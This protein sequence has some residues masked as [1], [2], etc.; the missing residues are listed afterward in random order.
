MA[1]ELESRG[2]RVVLSGNKGNLAPIWEKTLVDD[3]AIVYGFDFVADEPVSVYNADV[4]NYSSIARWKS[5]YDAVADGP[6][7]IIINNAAIDVP[8]HRTGINFFSDYVNTI[9]TNLIG[10][11]NLVSLFIDDMKKNRNGLIINIGSIQGNVAA[12]IRNYP[13]GFEKPVGYNV[14]KA[15]LIQFTR[16]LAVQYGAFNI[17]S[18]CLSFAA[19]DSGKF[20]EAFQKKFLHCLPLS[21]FISPKSLA[22]AL[23][24]TIACPELTGTQVLIDSGYTAW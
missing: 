20:D 10:A 1:G 13:P 12:D 7:D 21:R 14:S 18:V 15:G 2:K 23:R 6:P 8:P 16:S 4:S 22:A 19:I 9:M 17:R 24:F 3:G 5:I 11:I